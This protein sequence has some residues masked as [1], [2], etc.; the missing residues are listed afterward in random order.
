MDKYKNITIIKPNETLFSLLPNDLGTLE[1][2]EK[3]KLVEVATQ[4]VN[5]HGIKR[6]LI[7]L[8]QI[9]EES[10]ES[11]SAS[12]RDQAPKS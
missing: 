7:I 4:K 11:D 5:G 2:E 6:K 12:V 10:E 8:P 3:F 9:A 1:P